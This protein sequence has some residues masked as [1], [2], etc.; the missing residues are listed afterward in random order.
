MPAAR[1]R[2]GEHDELDVRMGGSLDAM[3]NDPSLLILVT[4]DGM[5]RTDTELQHKLAG[6]YLKL[7]D[8]NN[9]LPGAICFYADGV[10]LVVEGSPV[11]DQLRSLEKKG[12]HLVVCKTCLD[13]F[14][15][16]DK[17]KVGIVG[18]MTDIIEAQWRAAKVITI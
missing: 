7:L 15:M 12:V 10:K 2:A 18:G 16:L 13:F 3:I 4:N 9:M 8:E 14:G 11:L 5:G 6:I 1:L 17:V